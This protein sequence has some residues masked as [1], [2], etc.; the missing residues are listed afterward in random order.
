MDPTDRTAGPAGRRGPGCDATPAT[1]AP[2][3]AAALPGGRAAL[4]PR[5]HRDGTHGRRRRRPR[6]GGAP[7]P[8]AGPR[9]RQPRRAS[10]AAAAAGGREE[11]AG[12]EGCREEGA[13]QEGGGQEGPGEEGG[14]EEGCPSAARGRLTLHLRCLAGERGRRLVVV[15][16]R[17]GECGARLARPN[18]ASKED[19]GGVLLSSRVGRS[20]RRTVSSFWSRKWL[21]TNHF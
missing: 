4:A 16:G 5:R 2:R 18:A 7:G 11:G 13:G 6:P 15:A 17:V 12:E 20:D 10:G 14:G 9:R 19:A 1:A 8:R 3:P 21:G